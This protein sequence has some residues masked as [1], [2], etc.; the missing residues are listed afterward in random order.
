M[1]SSTLLKSKW[2]SCKK[3]MDIIRFK[4]WYYDTALAA[5]TEEAPK[6]M[7]AEEMPAE[8]QRYKRDFLG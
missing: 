6:N 2:K 5:G 7:P 4:C 3:T 8:I 1:S